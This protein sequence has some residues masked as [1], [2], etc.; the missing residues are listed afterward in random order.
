MAVGGVDKWQKR[1]DSG[2]GKGAGLSSRPAFPVME[3]IHRF[4]PC[5][6]REAIKP[7]CDEGVP[8]SG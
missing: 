1:T 7:A 2:G 8:A 3:S 5:F 4:S 6:K